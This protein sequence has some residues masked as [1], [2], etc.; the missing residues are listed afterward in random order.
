MQRLVVGRGSYYSISATP[1]CSLQHTLTLLRSVLL[2]L[3]QCGTLV[4]LQLFGAQ[5]RK[6]VVKDSFTI[7]PV[8]LNVCYYTLVCT[9]LSQSPKKIDWLRGV[10]QGKE[11]ITNYFLKVC[12]SSFESCRFG[13]FR[14]TSYSIRLPR[15]AGTNLFKLC[16]SI[17]IGGR[18]RWIPLCPIIY[19]RFSLS[20]S[21][22]RRCNRMQVM[23]PEQFHYVTWV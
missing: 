14:P 11:V 8:L 5:E 2:T 7:I 20:E 3:P 4:S 13:P 17:P 1:T 12:P 6:G 22:C 19:A 23:S 16:S 21:L 18:Q 10:Y 15:I 9:S